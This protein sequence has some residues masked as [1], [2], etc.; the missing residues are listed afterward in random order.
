MKDSWKSGNSYEYFMGRWSSLA[1]QG[2][3]DWLSP[4][5]G[6]KWLDVGCGSGA[7][8]EAVIQSYKPETLLAIDHSNKFVHVA[9]K[10]LGSKAICKVGNAVDLPIEDCSVELTVSGLVF[11]FL[12]DVG[13]ALTEMKRVTANGGT[14]AIYFGIMP[15]RWTSFRYFGK[16][17]QSLE[18]R[19][20]YLTKL[21][22]FRTATLM[23]L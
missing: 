20:L 1:A 23:H 13:K 4:A 12:P 14:V 7:L 2:F 16:R 19:H 3:L 18:M 15:A 8:S 22:D 21:L 6:L 17:Q 11:N 10:R 9:Q 5:H